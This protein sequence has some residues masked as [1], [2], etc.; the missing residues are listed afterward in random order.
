MSANLLPDNGESHAPPPPHPLPPLVPPDRRGVARPRTLSPPHQQAHR[1]P[2]EGPPRHLGRHL[3]G[4]R[5]QRL[6][7]GHPAGTPHRPRRRLQ[8]ALR[9]GQDRRPIPSP[10]RRLPPSLRGPGP[11][12]PGIPHR[13]HLPA[14]RPY[15]PAGGSAPRPHPRHGHRAARGSR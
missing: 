12:F 5:H 6:L 13:R 9:H 3:L 15:S 1:P 2:A 4:R 10:P 14:R 8:R 11:R 7:A